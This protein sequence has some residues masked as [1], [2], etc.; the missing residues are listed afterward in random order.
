MPCDSTGPSNRVELIA[1]LLSIHSR[2]LECS[3][4]NDIWPITNEHLLYYCET[5]LQT[6]SGMS[7]QRYLQ[8]LHSMGICKCSFTLADSLRHIAV[9]DY[10]VDHILF[11]EML[12]GLQKPIF[13]EYAKSISAQLDML[14]KIDVEDDSCCHVIKIG[15]F[16]HLEAFLY[17]SQYGNAAVRETIARFIEQM[18]ARLFPKLFMKLGWRYEQFLSEAGCDKGY[19]RV[20]WEGGAS[21]FELEPDFQ[22][23]WLTY[24]SSIDEQQH[25]SSDQIVSR[26]RSRWTALFDGEL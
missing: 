2:I 8:Y 19:C 16:R 11:S 26:L 21:F 17:P 25:S 14:K 10:A 22:A 7:F 18:I 9:E 5:C 4:A 3:S 6:L 20:Q 13:R 12:Q 23:F 15:V 1:E 24:L